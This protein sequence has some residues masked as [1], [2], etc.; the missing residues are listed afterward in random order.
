RDRRRAALELMTKLL[1]EDLSTVASEWG[2]PGSYAAI[3]R[4]LPPDQALGQAL[5]GV[6]SLAGFEL[7]AERI[8]VPLSSGGQEDEESCFS[9]T[10][11]RDLAANVDGIALVLAGDGGAPGLLTALAPEPAADIRARL[12]RIQELARG[13]QPPFERIIATRPDDPRRLHFQVL[14]GGLR[15]PAGAR[16]RAGSAANLQGTIG[17]GG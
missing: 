16:Q 3:F 7:A 2:S 11:H 13:T 12:A 6:A 10:T 1:V 17:P 14:E 15:G 5:S 4:A 9:D 8:G